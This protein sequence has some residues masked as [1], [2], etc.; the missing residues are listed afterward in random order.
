MSCHALV[1]V[2][3]KMLG[4]GDIVKGFE[5]MNQMPYV[6]ARKAVSHPVV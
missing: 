1:Y 2:P 6:E 5:K 4:G 3:F